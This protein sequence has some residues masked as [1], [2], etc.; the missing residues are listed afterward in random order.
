MGWQ[1]MA[2]ML[3]ELAA[4]HYDIQRILLKIAAAGDCGLPTAPAIVILT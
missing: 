2:Q 4:Q 3:Q 1:K